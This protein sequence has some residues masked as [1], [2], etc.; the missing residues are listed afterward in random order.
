MGGGR[1]YMFPKNQS[2]VE[3]PGEKK[4]FGTRIDRRN[5]VEEWNNRMKN[6]VSCSVLVLLSLLFY[7][8]LL[9]L[10][11]FRPPLFNIFLIKNI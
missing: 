2:D 11:F 7:H 6:K 9:F 8:V 5:L 3:Y 10:P 1:K 4:H